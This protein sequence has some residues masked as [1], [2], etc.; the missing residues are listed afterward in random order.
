MS[1]SAILG[2]VK[3]GVQDYGF[4]SLK[5][6]IKS[7]EIL[8]LAR[9]HGISTLDT[10]PRYS[11]SEGAIGEYHAQNTFMFKV[12]TKVDNLDVASLSSGKKIFDSV[13]NSIRAT[14]V[15]HIET[16]YLHQNEMEIITDRIII[17]SLMEL[18]CSGL[19]KKIGVSIY[20]FEECKFALENNF[21]DVIQIPISILD[22][23][24]YSSLISGKS[25]NKEIIGRS[26]FLQGV[27]FNREDIE[28]KIKQSK[29]VFEYVSKLDDLA[30]EYNMDLITMACSF[31]F[32]LQEV[33]GIVIGT[34]VE[35]NLIDIIN[36]SKFKMTEELRCRLI[37]LSCEYKEWG[38]P[39]N[40]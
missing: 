36:A 3:F 9:K 7:G 20:S 21:Y 5:N 16:L 31:V 22:S 39:R 23:F 32:S 34:A 37:E 27:L 8:D 12:C 19:V 4:S 13:V 15:N 1:N 40:W 29:Q 10:S 17:D 18:K 30:F 26:I 11:N 38:N 28:N 14:G 33:D 24:I 2:T 6:Q 35:K 25:S